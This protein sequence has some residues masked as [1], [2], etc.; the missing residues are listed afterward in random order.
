V[1]KIAVMAAA[2]IVYAAAV[3]AATFVSG[4]AVVAVASVGALLVAA[5]YVG[6]GVALGGRDNKKGG[7][8]GQQK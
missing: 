5:V 4:N 7:G 6:L 3:L 8:D 2:P 1:N